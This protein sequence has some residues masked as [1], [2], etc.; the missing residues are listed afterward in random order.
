M[1]VKTPG[2]TRRVCNKF[3]V[4]DLVV[5]F[6]WMSETRHQS[7]GK[8]DE[9]SKR[10]G[11]GQMTVTRPVVKT[12][13]LKKTSSCR[14][15]WYTWVTCIS[16]HWTVIRQPRIIWFEHKFRWCRL[17]R[18]EVFTKR[19]NHGFFHEKNIWD[20]TIPSTSL[21]LLFLTLTR[22]CA[23]RFHTLNRGI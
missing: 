17:V 18:W 9:K 12:G 20:R 8:K 19:Q 5:Q 7:E 22:A 15:Q 14:L 1:I 13:K 10:G 4:F 11:E 16:R 3:C 6:F 23:R 21:Y 2:K